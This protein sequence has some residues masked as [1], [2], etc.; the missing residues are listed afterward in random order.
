MSNYKLLTSSNPKTMKSVAFGYATVILHLSPSGLSGKNLC[1]F[2]TKGCIKSCLNTSGHGKF[3]NVQLARL[4]RSALYNTNIEK[5]DAMLI[6]DIN[7]AIKI[8]AKANLI[9]AVRLDGTSD[10]DWTRIIKLFPMVQFYDYTKDLNKAINNK[11]AN[12]HLTFSRSESNHDDCLKAIEHGINVA[13]VFNKLPATFMGLNVVNGDTSDLR[14]LDAK[15]VV[16]GL[17]AKG[18]A[19]LDDTNFVVRI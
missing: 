2:A 7:K 18:K 19:K 9:L 12:Y 10:Q 4:G 8:A 14:F 5:F 3:D 11:L 15:N 17:T 6:D 13:V 1:P 16:I